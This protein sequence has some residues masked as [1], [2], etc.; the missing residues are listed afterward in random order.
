MVVNR[1]GY[2]SKKGTNTGIEINYLSVSTLEENEYIKGRYDCDNFSC[3]CGVC[4]IWKNA[5]DV[6]RR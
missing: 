4:P 2:C 1:Y 6:I 5:P 3:E